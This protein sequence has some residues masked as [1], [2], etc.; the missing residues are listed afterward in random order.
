M[1]QS[2]FLKKHLYFLLTS[3]DGVRQGLRYHPEGDVLYHSLQVFQL[4]LQ[5][6]DDCE[7]WAAALLHDIGK[8][9]STPQH[10]DIGADELEGLL[11]PRIVWLVRHHLHLLVA[12]KLTRRWLRN[13]PQLRELE[14]LHAWDLDGRLP[15][16]SVI[17]PKEAINILMEHASVIMAG[18][19]PVFYYQNKLL[20]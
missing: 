9:V 13:T 5:A 12:P 14:L 19:K 3:L 6:C 7:L 11:S 4:S 1:T 2:P 15:N 8:A 18:T 20:D 16:A 10:A 17:Q